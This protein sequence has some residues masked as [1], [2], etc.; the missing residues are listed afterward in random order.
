MLKF[1]NYDSN[2]ISTPVFGTSLLQP[3][4]I[5]EQKRFDLNYNEWRKRR[6]KV[7]G[8]RGREFADSSSEE[9]Y[10]HCLSTVWPWI[11]Q[12]NFIKTKEQRDWIKQETSLLHFKFDVLW[13]KT[14][15]NHGKKRNIFIYL[16][17]KELFSD[18][19]NFHV[20]QV[21][22]GFHEWIGYWNMSKYSKWSN[23]W[24]FLMYFLF[25]NIL[26]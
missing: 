18:S 11:K 21:L 13:I 24:T 3:K 12:R 16:D 23:Y 14:L 19:E 10:T 20:N 4:L 2:F 5:V 22:P 15:N 1:Q 26:K 7:V 17:L 6:F 8:R 25:E 9:T